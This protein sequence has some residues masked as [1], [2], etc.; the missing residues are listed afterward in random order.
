MNK[1]FG[2]PCLHL[3]HLRRACR[4]GSTCCKCVCLSNAAGYTRAE[5]KGSVSQ[6]TEDLHE[7]FWFNATALN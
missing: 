5:G 6:K 7:F 3:R 2:D 1:S 4:R